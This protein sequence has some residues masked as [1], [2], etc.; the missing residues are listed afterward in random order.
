MLTHEL[1]VQLVVNN[2]VGMLPLWELRN[3]SFKGVLEPK[4]LSNWK[5][6][7][8]PIGKLI[9]ESR[10]LEMGFFNL[11][12]NLSFLPMTPSS[13]NNAKIGI[14]QVIFQPSLRLLWEGEREDFCLAYSNNKNDKYDHL[15]LRNSEILWRL[16]PITVDRDFVISQSPFLETWGL[17]K[18]KSHGIKVFS[19]TLSFTLSKECLSDL[20]DLIDFCKKRYSVEYWNDYIKLLR[21]DYYQNFLK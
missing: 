15:V 11:T 19:E 14:N 18:E 10:L 7:Y 21:R 6:G 3:Q 20:P 16:S 13:C 4:F 12:Q 2:P 17:G 1:D 5:Y 8:D 9:I